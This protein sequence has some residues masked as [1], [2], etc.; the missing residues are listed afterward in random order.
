MLIT[1]AVDSIGYHPL[2]CS[3]L[4]GKLGAG[5]EYP[6]PPHPLQQARGYALKGGTFYYNNKT[7]L[8]SG[9]AEKSV[10]T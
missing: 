8:W 4:N 1:T 9:I 7:V 3:L 6:S 10:L 5:S 2:P